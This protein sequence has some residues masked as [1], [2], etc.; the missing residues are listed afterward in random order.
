MTNYTGGATATPQLFSLPD[1]ATA[2]LCFNDVVAIGLTRALMEGGVSVGV[3]FDV[4]GFDDI[5]EAST[6]F[7]P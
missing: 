6:R 5:E 4:I 2:A 1:P 7:P 3:E